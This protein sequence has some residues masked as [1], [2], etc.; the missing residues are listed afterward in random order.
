MIK[1]ADLSHEWPKSLG[2]KEV[3]DGVTFHFFSL[4]IPIC[5]WLPL[6]HVHLLFLTADAQAQH[7]DLDAADIQVCMRGYIYIMNSLFSVTHIG[8]LCLIKP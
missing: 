3:K 2:L 6:F 5:P 1:D 4:Q 7:Q 8:S